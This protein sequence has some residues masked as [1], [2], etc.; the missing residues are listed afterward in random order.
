MSFQSSVGGLALPSLLEFLDLFSRFRYWW[1]AC[2]LVSSQAPHRHPQL[3]PV[4]DKM[5]FPFEWAPSDL[6]RSCL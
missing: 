2:H 1:G 5:L 6:T 3:V 4:R